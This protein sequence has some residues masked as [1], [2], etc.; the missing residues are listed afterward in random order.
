[1]AGVPGWLVPLLLLRVLPWGD[2]ACFSGIATIP[3][4]PTL[5]LSTLLTDA[6]WIFCDSSPGLVVLPLLALPTDPI[7]IGFDIGLDA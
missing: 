2:P 3:M 5:S 7:D 6:A 4:A 1:M